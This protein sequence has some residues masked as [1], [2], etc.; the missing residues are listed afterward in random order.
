VACIGTWMTDFRDDLPR[1]DVPMLDIHGDADHVLTLDKTSGRLPG[2]IKDTAL[3]DFLRTGKRSKGATMSNHFS[4]DISGSPAT[5]RGWT[6]PMCTHS[7][8]LRIRTRQC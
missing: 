3:L 5:T 6:S 2:L 8:R 4:A 1:I 7:G